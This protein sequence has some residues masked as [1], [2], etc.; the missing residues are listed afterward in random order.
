MS[1][2]D[3]DKEILRTI[4]K[5]AIEEILTGKRIETPELPAVLQEKGGAFVTLK[6][7]G[8]LRGCIGYT[9]ASL[10]LH[11]TVSTVA[12]QA[13]FHDPRFAALTKDEWNDTDLELSVLT[14]MKKITSLDEIEVGRHG[15]Y[16]EKGFHSGLLLPQVAVEYGWDR[17][18]FLD[19]TCMKAGLPKNSW[20]SKDVSIFVFSAEIF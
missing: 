14:P 12:V 3:R 6:R 11:E 7:K 16:I 1:L 5:I 13:A 20:K 10:P 4:A 9:S 2:S 8:D 18:T 15:I 17:D 19:Y